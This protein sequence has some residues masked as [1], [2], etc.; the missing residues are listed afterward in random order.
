M[1]MDDPDFHIFDRG[2]VSLPDCQPNGIG[3]GEYTDEN[4]DSR[5]DPGGYRYALSYYA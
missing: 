1:L 3:S 4:F 2:V 5:V